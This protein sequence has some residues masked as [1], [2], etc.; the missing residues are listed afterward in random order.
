LP[1]FE[2]VL[3][4][5]VNVWESAKEP[6]H[7]LGVRA[8][9]LYVINESAVPL[10]VIGEVLLGDLYFV[11]VEEMGDEI[12]HDLCVRGGCAHSCSSDHEFQRIDR[13]VLRRLRGARLAAGRSF[14]RE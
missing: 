14:Y 4:D 11:L 5:R 10:Q 9:T 2:G 13:R 3:L 6:V 1:A 8:N 7:N 12:A